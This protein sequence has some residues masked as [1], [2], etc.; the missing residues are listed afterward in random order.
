MPRPGT[1]S[2]VV[3]FS[4]PTRWEAGSPVPGFSGRS[5]LDAPPKPH[6]YHHRAATE[7]YSR[8]NSKKPTAEAV[9]SLGGR[10]QARAGRECATGDRSI[11]PEPRQPSV[12]WFTPHRGPSGSGLI[13]GP[14]PAEDT[15]GWLTG[16]HRRVKLYAS[17]KC[18]HGSR[19]FGNM[20]LVG[21][22]RAAWSKIPM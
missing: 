21:S 1:R 6:F 18:S 5:R 19:S 12:K 9:G 22:R 10:R 16:R 7:M 14:A 8:Q 13:V 2:R 3:E 11:L 20:C 17:A 4:D 15:T